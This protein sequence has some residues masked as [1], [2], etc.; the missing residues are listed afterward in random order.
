MH[1][2]RLRQLLVW[3]CSTARHWRRRQRLPTRIHL[4]HCLLVPARI[5]ALR[6]VVSGIGVNKHCHAGVVVVHA[7]VI[8]VVVEAIMLHHRCGA[9]Y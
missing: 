5:H 7:R 4:M 8:V 9:Y 6:A 2:Q 3:C 1:Y